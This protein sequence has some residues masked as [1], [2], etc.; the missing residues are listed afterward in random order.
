MAKA[1]QYFQQ[2]IQKDPNYALAY[3]GLSDYFA[4]LTLMGGPEILPPS[5]AMP[6]AKQ[7]AAKAVQLDD[8]SAE[9]HASNGHILHNYDWDWEGGERELKRAIELN[10]LAC[11]APFP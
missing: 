11:T 3:S 10:K 8:S 5:Q 7:A 6:K 9:A 1:G 4:F 2:A